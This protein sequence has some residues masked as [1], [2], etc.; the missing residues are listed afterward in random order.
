MAQI[1]L[2]ITQRTAVGG[3]R[4]RRL[5]RAGLIPAVVYGGEGGSFPVS[6]DRRYLEQEIGGINENQILSL[7][8]GEQAPPR[9]AIVKEIQRNHLTDAVIHIDFEEITLSKK[10]TATVPV[11]RLGEAAGVRDGGIMEQVLREISVRC[12]PAQ[13]PEKIEVDVSPLAI[14]DSIQVKDVKF[15]EGIEILTDPA[16]IIFTVSVPKAEEEVVP[17]A[18]EA[19]APEAIGEEKEGEAGPAEG[20]KP[21][22]GKGKEAPGVKGK[23]APGVKGKEAPGVKGKEAP[24]VKGKEAP[25]VKGKE[26]PAGKGKEAPAGKGKEPT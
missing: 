2:K 16:L 15:A 17:A 21:E 13:L 12:L 26:A 19:A 24:G 25:G 22:A 7:L 3:Q 4:P 14:G 5:R 10:L 8:V 6:L 20:E 11:I 23:E 9:L 1:E 18:E